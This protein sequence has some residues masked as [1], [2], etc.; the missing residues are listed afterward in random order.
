MSDFFINQGITVSG[1]GR[2]IAAL[3]ALSMKARS[4]HT[5]TR[6]DVRDAAAV[7]RWADRELE[8]G[9][10]PD[11]LINNA[12]LIAPNAPLWKLTPGEI[13]PV[14][15]TNIKGPI[16][17]IRHFLPAMIAQGSG[18]IVNISSGWGHSTAPDVACYCATKWAIEGL[19]SSLAQ[20]LPHGLA[21]VALNPGMIHT[22]MLCSCFGEDAKTYPSPQEWIQYAGPFLLSL[23]VKD[24]GKSLIVPTSKK[25][26]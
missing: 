14:I 8:L 24:N 4:P 9:P 18:V 22:D 17:V 2:N 26:S 11:L 13:D 7:R 21:A 1:C 23:G 5:F 20:D 16:N 10:P 6:V 25:S 15:D 19:T 12:A 3:N